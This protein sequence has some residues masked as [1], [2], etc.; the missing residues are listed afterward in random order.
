MKTNGVPQNKELRSPPKQASAPVWVIIR[1]GKRTKSREAQRFVIEQEIS[2]RLRAHSKSKNHRSFIDT[3]AEF[4]AGY[5]GQDR[6]LSRVCAARA[7]AMAMR[8]EEKVT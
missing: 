4:D 7:R 3:F 5:R 8:P 6:A 2:A 1:M